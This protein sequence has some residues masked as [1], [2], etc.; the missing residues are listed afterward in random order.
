MEKLALRKI[1]AK[2]AK[3]EAKRA[4]EQK[5]RASKVGKKVTKEQQLYLNKLFGIPN[6]PVGVGAVTRDGNA[7]LWWSLEGA[8]NGVTLEPWVEIRIGKEGEE[9]PDGSRKEWNMTTVSLAKND[10][11]DMPPIQWSIETKEDFE[12]N[13]ATKNG[14]L[15]IETKREYWLENTLFVRISD[16][17]S[18]ILVAE[19]KASDFTSE[20]MYDK[21][22]PPP[23]PPTSEEELELL[24]E[25]G[26]SMLDENGKKIMYKKKKKKPPK[27]K[28]KRPKDRMSKEQRK[29]SGKHRSNHESGD[30]TSE[31]DSRPSSN[32][33]TKRSGKRKSSSSSEIKNKKDNA[34]LDSDD[35]IDETPSSRQSSYKGNIKSSTGSGSGS[36][37]HGS[38]SS[39]KRGSSGERPS[40]SS[41]SSKKKRPSFSSRDIDEASKDGD[42]DVDTVVTDDDGVSDSASSIGNSRASTP[43]N[44][45]P[46]SRQAGTGAADINKSGY[47]AEDEDEGGLG[48]GLCA[49]GSAVL[50][51][52]PWGDDDDGSVGG[53]M[54]MRNLSLDDPQV[55]NPTPSGLSLPLATTPLSS[56]K[57]SSKGNDKDRDKDKG[58][59]V[60]L[61]VHD[62]EIAEEPP[63]AKIIKEEDLVPWEEWFQDADGFDDMGRPLIIAFGGEMVLMPTPPRDPIKGFIVEVPLVDPRNDKDAGVFSIFMRREPLNKPKTEE[64]EI[65]D[66]EI[67]EDETEE[68]KKAREKARKKKLKKLK[69][70]KK[71]QKKAEKKKNKKK[72]EKEELEAELN[73]GAEEKEKI[74]PNLPTDIIHLGGKI[75]VKDLRKVTFAETIIGWEIH[76]YRN[77]KGDWKYKG[78]K[79]LDHL[80]RYQCI[81]DELTEGFMYR[82]TIKARNRIGLSPESEESNPVIIEKALPSGW[83]RYFDQKR[84]KFYYA[85]IKTKQST[86]ARPDTDFYFLEESVYLNFEKREILHLRELFDEE[87]IHFA[88]VRVSRFVALMLECGERLNKR[89]VTSLYK[90]YAQNDE[91]ITL[92]S[93]WVAIINHI[94][95]EKNTPL[96]SA[97]S[98]NIMLFFKRQVVANLLPQENKFGKWKVEYNDMLAKQFFV[99]SETGEMVWDMPDEI[100]F[101]IPPKLEDKLL[102][103]FTPGHLEA[104]KVKFSQIDVDGSGD[105]SEVEMRLLLESMGVVVNNS[106]FKTL[107][108]IVD[109]NGNGTIEFDEFCYMLLMMA[110]K[111]QSG[112]FANIAIPKG[113]SGDDEHSLASILSG[114]SF[115]INS[116]GCGAVRLAMTMQQLDGDESVGSSFDDGNADNQFDSL[117]LTEWIESKDNT[118]AIGHGGLYDKYDPDLDRPAFSNPFKEGSIESTKS[119][120]MG[121]VKSMASKVSSVVIGIGTFII[122]KSS[123]IAVS[124]GEGLKAKATEAKKSITESFDPAAMLGFEPNPG[125]HGPY[126][127]CGCRKIYE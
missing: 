39:G 95:K 8:S 33:S 97:P 101:F 111:D 77:D 107:L 98:P 115:D 63:A 106:Q 4:L 83:F 32:R 1:A 57:R 49:G 71:N 96:I 112:A 94:K 53:S 37:K 72:A 114:G 123:K 42:T 86:W 44:S 116:V 84:T 12:H 110:Q 117:K 119:D 56:T 81:I 2:H 79:V 55:L 50:P 54:T 58:S 90:A 13:A 67:P 80:D 16:S 69:K 18:G 7:S 70:L 21:P 120:V 26:D 87:M 74:D 104:F 105:I 25:Y 93:Q 85:N 103:Q 19:G 59:E 60:A 109:L 89:K 88:K 28:K 118:L 35:A 46:S 126:C 24:D 34:S 125:P 22:P 62:S 31:N 6:P 36:G 41:R 51:A 102:E 10:L 5:Q 27:K 14:E 15:Q 100:R 61:D 64:D 20:L 30:G 47:F 113:E 127:F 76:R 3:E 40:S 124:I 108:N 43:A 48:L 78:F 68:E 82:F 91:N 121:S 52:I 9:N 66:E 23:S 122:G 92:W 17:I 11:G 75:E 29:R 45:R 73:A 38:S 99:N 65:E